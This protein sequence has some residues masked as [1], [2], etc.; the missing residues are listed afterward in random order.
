M[1]NILSLLLIDLLAYD[2]YNDPMPKFIDSHAHLTFPD[3]GD[4]LEAVLNRAWEAGL[5]YIITVGAGDGLEGNAEA[6]HLAD[7][8][9]RVY[10]TVGIHPHDAKLFTDNTF[11]TLEELASH[12]KVVA[13]GEI[14]LDFH[15]KHSSRAEQIYAFR[16]QLD[17][18]HE[19]KK[20]VII[21]DR[22][23]HDEMLK[24]LD[25]HGFPKEGILFHCFSG[26]IDFARVLI[27][28]G[29]NLSIPGIVT[30]KNAHDM[31]EVAANAPLERLFIETDSPYLA[32]HPHRGK[33]NEP[34]YVVEVAAMI[35]QLK[36]LHLDDVARVT[37]LNTKR[38]FNLPGAD[39]EYS[40]A[41]QIRNSLYL[42]VTNRCNLACVFCPKH[43]DYEVKGHY[44]KLEN[45]PNVEEVFQAMGNPEK[46]DEVVFC[47]YGEPTLRL[48][49]IKIIA[50]R[51]KDVHAKKIR[52]N[53]D[54]LA[55]LV[56][57]RD[58]TKELKG[59]IDSVSVSLNAPDAVSYAK[60]CPSKYKDKAYEAVKDF[61]L[62][63][64]E[65]IPEVVAT[66]VAMPEI[67]IDACQRIAEKDLGVKFRAREYMNLG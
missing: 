64:K 61:I 62:K 46:Y 18:A 27:E 38:L 55:N 33:R 35:A 6:I 7:E 5:E 59:L 9:K 36:N 11:K 31:R 48:E 37:T 25:K 28:E 39:V 10:A 12:P 21:H 58:V 43:I 57:G 67:D 3:F 49:L 29:A 23:A 30:Y 24:I 13:I 32:P 1:T 52:L 56:Y 66:A 17:L 26:D 34:S 63:A 54:G 53:T 50:K 60:I 41:Y 8:E 14:G 22:E 2:I 47:G 42:N 65:S 40:I 44:L 20:P 4:D 16:R 45:E 15:Y 19:L 51:M